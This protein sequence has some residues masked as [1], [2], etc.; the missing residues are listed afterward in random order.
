[1]VAELLERFNLFL[2]VA[3]P[4]GNQ[5]LSWTMMSIQMVCLIRFSKGSVLCARQIT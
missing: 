4:V 2:L 1:M 3:G 5:D